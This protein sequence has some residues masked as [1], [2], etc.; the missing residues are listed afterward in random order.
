MCFIN[1][2]VKIHS[3][4][5]ESQSYIVQLIS[6]VNG[7]LLLRWRDYPKWHKDWVLCGKSLCT[8]YREASVKG[9]PQ[10]RSGKNTG[11]RRNLIAEF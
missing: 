3:R 2:I 11:S 5:R 1:S 6:G 7:P 10:E 8:K 9:R 4:R